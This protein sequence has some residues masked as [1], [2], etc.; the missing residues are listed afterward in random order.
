[1][2]TISTQALTVGAITDAA[3]LEH[4]YSL[5]DTD[6]I[7]LRL[8]ALGAGEEVIDFARRHS[9]ALPL[10]ITARAPEEGGLGQHDLTSRL[11]L[12]RSLLPFASLIDIETANHELYQD[13]LEEAAAREVATVFSYH[14]FEEF[15]HLET[16]ETLARAQALGAT[17]AKA[18]VTVRDPLELTLFESLL[19]EMEGVPFSL[20]GMG[21]YGP[22]S[23]L[24]AAQ[25][26]SVLNYGYLGAQATAPGQWPAPLLKQVLGATPPFANYP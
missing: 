12:L 7:E 19:A 18:A 17:I 14:D 3:A 20:M 1:M 11:H 23:R 26:G 22:A 16:I 21:K 25:H 8:D 4:N 5:Q 2:F 6:L 15:D 13:L 24:L 10:L 9:P